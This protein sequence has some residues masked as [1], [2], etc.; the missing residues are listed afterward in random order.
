MISYPSYY[1]L[2]FSEDTKKR[3]GSITSQPVMVGIYPVV[4]RN[5]YIHYHNLYHLEI[6]QLDRILMGKDMVSGLNGFY[7]PMYHDEEFEPE[8]DGVLDE[9]RVAVHEWWTRPG[10]Y[11][12]L[13][14][15]R[16]SL[17]FI[18][19]GMNPIAILYRHWKS[20]QNFKHHQTNL[21][22]DPSGAYFE[23][24]VAPKKDSVPTLE[25]NPIVSS[26]MD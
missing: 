11:N 19:A 12:T 10:I 6:S 2:L 13:K 18:F 3:L 9:A 20:L 22:A 25:E 23:F 7:S 4:V 1:P 16:W 26:S 17:W 14:M 15:I 5:Y 24:K 21:N 8:Y